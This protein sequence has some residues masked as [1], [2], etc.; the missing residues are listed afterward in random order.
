MLR[1]RKDVMNDLQSRSYWL[2][3]DTYT[4]EA[5]LAEDLR[6]DVALVGG[7]FTS[8]WTAYLLLKADP[9]LQVAILEAHAVGYGASGR[10]GG[11]AMTLVHRTLTH[12]AAYVGDAEARK[13]YL[14]AKAAIDHL[15]ETVVAEAIACDYQPNGLLTLSNTPPQDRLIHSEMETA[16]RLGLEDDFA[17][18]D[19]DAAQAQIHSDKIRC[20]FREDACTLVNPARLARGL[21]EVVRRLGARVYEGTPVSA[22][23]ERADGVVLTTPGGVVTAGRAL[24]AGNAYATA[25]KPTRESV[26]PF[27]SYICLTRPLTEAEWERIGW[28]GR[29]GAEDRR[30]GLHY[31]RPTIDGRIL[32]GGRDPVFHPDGPKAAYDRDEAVFARM[33]ES[34]VWFFPQLQEVPFTHRWGGAIG[35]TGNFMPAVGWFDERRRRVAFAYGYNGHGVAISNLAAHVVADLFA[36]RQSAWTDLSFVGRPPENLGPHFIRDPL[37]RMTV[38]AQIRADDE[39]RETKEPLVLRL[40]NKVTGADIKV[41]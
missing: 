26:L 19:R 34:F 5:P 17:F 39:E 32:W 29:E 40:L 13:I 31:F 9:G 25:W 20:A 6:V 41:T 33:R 8:L 3:L 37:V 23:E 30:L 2:G 7:G 10:N 38:K 36:G 22:W 12:L 11:F 1:K 15:N 27:Y 14:A 24:V 4:S 28:R 21:K 16:H 35:V 18:L